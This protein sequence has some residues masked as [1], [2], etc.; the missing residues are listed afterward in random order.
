VREEKRDRQAA[1]REGEG[2]G[3]RENGRERW[4]GHEGRRRREERVVP[5]VRGSTAMCVGRWDL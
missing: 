4:G 5:E 2:E 3:E 1:G